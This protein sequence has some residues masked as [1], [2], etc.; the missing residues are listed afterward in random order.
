MAMG[1]MSSWI[2]RTCGT[3]ITVRQGGGFFFDLLH[4][5]RCG[6]D[7]SVA[8]EE[9]GDTHL[10]FVKGLPGPYAVVR[11][12]FDRAIQ[13]DYPGE[14]LSPAEYHEA[15]EASLEPCSCGGRFRY[16]A[17]ERC[18]V[19]GSTSDAWERDPD[20]ISMFYD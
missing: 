7:R 19:C 13:R 6:A 12:K 3:H 8:H 5:E 15:V 1:Q 14:P 20:G 11:S 2:C 16:D 10:R 18:R 9:M 17:P 4:C